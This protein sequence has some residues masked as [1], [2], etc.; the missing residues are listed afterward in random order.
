[1]KKFIGFFICSLC[2]ALLSLPGF[3]QAGTLDSTF[4][5]DGMTWF[6]LSDGSND[7]AFD[8]VALPDTTLLVCGRLT[9]GV[10]AGFIM[11]VLNDGEQDTAFGTNGLVEI[12]YGDFGTEARRLIVLPNNKIV[13]SGHARITGTD[14]RE[15]FIA[16]F[17]PDGLP[18]LTFNSTGHWVSSYGS[19]LETHYDMIMQADGKFI[20]AGQTGD[21][22]NLLFMRVNANGTIDNSFGTN[23][24]TAISISTSTNE[25]VAEVDVLSNGTIAGV[26][27]YEYTAGNYKFILVKLTPQGNPMPGFGTK[28]Y[29]YTTTVQRLYHLQTFRICSKK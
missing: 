19:G 1:M 20:M 8:V 26:G 18:D 4:S 12:Q 21:G 2:L 9:D 7:A 23:G 25:Y 15:F 14:D 24:Y 5:S 17:L 22:T 11:R 16:R 13:V 29:Y 28:W 10:Y 6:S 3:P 27:C